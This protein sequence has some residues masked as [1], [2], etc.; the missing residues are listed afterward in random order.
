MGLHCVSGWRRS[1]CEQRREKGREVGRRA[2]GSTELRTHPG[3][4][5]GTH[6]GIPS[7]KA[8]ALRAAR[9]QNQSIPPAFTTSFTPNLWLTI[10]GRAHSCPA[11]QKTAW[12]PRR[13]L[14]WTTTRL[15]CP[16][17]TARTAAVFPSRLAT[18]RSSEPP[19]AAT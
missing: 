2:A 15:L 8:Q 11:V 12:K 19:G 9:N 13:I 14:L 6:T 16:S 18:G 4:G 3:G 1:R 10:L 17:C 7:N 5:G